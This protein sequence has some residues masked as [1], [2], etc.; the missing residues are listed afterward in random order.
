M[1]AARPYKTAESLLVM[2]IN[3]N[4]VDCMTV[5][6]FRCAQ[7]EQQLR[8]GLTAAIVGRVRISKLEVQKAT[9]EQINNQAL[10]C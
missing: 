10:L 6:S 9:K 4:V 5:E 7:V 1:I 2:Q 3:V 8:D